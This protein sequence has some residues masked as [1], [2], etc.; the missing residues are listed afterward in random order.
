MWAWKGSV[1]LAVPSPSPA[2]PGWRE[3]QQLA[4]VLAPGVG[5]AALLPEKWQDREHL[6]EPV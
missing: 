2:G 5:A 4:L 1:H 3:P 6:E